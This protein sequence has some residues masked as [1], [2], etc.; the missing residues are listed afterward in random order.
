[1]SDKNI[2][3]NKEID[4]SN[5]PK[6]KRGNVDWR[7]STGLIVN[8]TYGN[9]TGFFKILSCN[10][11]TCKCTILY[12]E[13]EYELYYGRIY[14]CSLGG[15]LKYSPE[16]KYN[17]GYIDE[18]DLEI[19]D[20][21]YRYE[22]RRQKKYYKYKCLTCGCINYKK[23]ENIGKSNC[24]VCSKSPKKVVKGINDIGTVAQWMVPYFYNK[25]DAYIN[26]PNTSK[27]VTM[28]CPKCKSIHKNVSISS[29]YS[30]GKLSCRCQDGWSYPNK[31]VAEFLKQLNI[32][33]ECEK[34]FSWSNGKRYDD[35]IEFENKKIIIENQGNIHYEETGL[36]S[37]SLEQIQENDKYKMN[38][39]INN[40]I[41][42]YIYLDCRK[43]EQE[44]IKK[45]ILNSQLPNI[46]NFKHDLIDWDKCGIVSNKST[47]FDIC[48]YKYMFPECTSS[49]IAKYFKPI[50]IKTVIRYLKIGTKYGWCNYDTTKEMKISRENGTKS[51]P[52]HCISDNTYYRN[53]KICSEK[54]SLNSRN[55]RS[56]CLG[57]YNTY[58]GFIFKYI[59]K[60]EFNDYKCEHSD[61]CYG[62]FFDLDK[63]KPQKL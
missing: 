7:K 42:Y 30:S 62:N 9:I 21:E 14:S 1:M 20:A 57:E 26:F 47:V 2:R 58:K 11:K 27:K 43:S 35:Y 15:I 60:E 12:K 17:V 39:A 3:I 10:V 32:K 49:D 22:N 55:I 44:F 24:P 40:G 19:L 31:F 23:E 59:S 4:L 5:L 51:K 48:N 6:N 28:I 25:N 46:L 36:T 53:A 33:Y 61:K 50:S 56:V 52:I 13:N 63:Q 34:T 38:L 45:S 41:D 16:F 54:M 18:N 8:F 37:L 29:V